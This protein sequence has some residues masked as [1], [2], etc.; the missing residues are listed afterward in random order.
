M[1]LP[2]NAEHHKIRKILEISSLIN[3]SLEIQTVLNNALAAV[4]QFIQVETS[5]IFELDAA[6][7][8]LYFSCARGLGAEKLQ[9]QRLKIGAGIAGY[10]AHTEKPLIVADARQDPR[11]LSTFDDL[12]GFT[13]R[14][15]LCVPLKVKRRLVG[16][17]ELLNKRDGTDFDEEDVEIVSIL[18]NQIGIALEN[19][20][21]Y[22]KLQEKLLV[23]VEE[24]KFTQSRL[25]Q[26]ERLAALGKL[27]QGV[28]HEVRNPAAIIGGLAHLVSK[29]LP[30]EDPCQEILEQI[31]E[32][33][34]RLERMVKEVEFFAK[35]PAARL[36]P[37]QVTEVIQAALAPFLPQFSSQGVSLKITAP[38]DLPPIPLDAELLGLVLQHLIQNALEAMPS[39]GQLSLT[40]ALE[41]QSL[42]LTLQDTGS[43]IPAEIL[44]LVFD[45]FFS[46]K[47]H[48]SG[49]GLTIVHRIVAEH[50]G[51]LRL[52]STEGVGTTLDLWLPRW[53]SD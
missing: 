8:E 45:P 37:A 11:F 36:S 39:G 35:L 47:P 1:T 19:A 27:A 12:T 16:V 6:C 44:P 34:S 29:K 24:L 10:V 43:G 48:G 5:S 20:R 46:T 50:K 9:G 18:A 30:G 28:A 52:S 25:L 7:G 41:A 4:E 31:R 13:T 21:L 38:P 32:A 3:S 42:R 2:H 17:L 40:A 26:S 51:E 15:V 14:S 22:A 23:T 53:L 49:M 33:A